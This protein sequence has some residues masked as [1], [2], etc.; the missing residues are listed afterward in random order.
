MDEDEKTPK[1][2]NE[3][4]LIGKCKKA[5]KENVIVIASNDGDNDINSTMT[6]ALISLCETD[7]EKKDAFSS[8]VQRC[9]QVESNNQGK[10]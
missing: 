4:D 9:G 5:Y 6:A 2:E 8:A 3:E 10:P 1:I 7:A